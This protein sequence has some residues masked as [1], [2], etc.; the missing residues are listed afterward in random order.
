MS[1]KFL[2]NEEV[3]NILCESDIDYMSDVEEDD[4]TILYCESERKV[5]VKKTAVFQLANTVMYLFV[6]VD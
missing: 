5:R 3:E 6:K 2:S 1:R 4:E